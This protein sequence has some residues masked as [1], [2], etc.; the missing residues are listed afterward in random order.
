MK[1]WACDH[2]LINPS[3]KY[4]KFGLGIIC[5]KKIVEDEWFEVC[6]KKLC[7][8][9]RVDK[10]ESVE[11]P[12]KSSLIKQNSD[13]GE[14]LLIL[15]SVVKKFTNPKSGKGKK[16]D[17]CLKCNNERTQSSDTAFDEFYSEIIDAQVNVSEQNQEPLD[18]Y[19]KQAIEESKKE[20]S[21]KFDGKGT[22]TEDEQTI[23]NSTFI[24]KVFLLSSKNWYTLNHLSKDKI[25][26]IKSFGAKSIAC[27]LNRNNQPVP[28][29]LSHLALNQGSFNKLKVRFS[30]TC[31]KEF[32]NQAMGIG[33][34]KSGYKANGDC[35]IIMHFNDLILEF[36]YSKD[37]TFQSVPEIQGYY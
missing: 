23:F 26:R 11:H 24:N 27:S 6:N 14:Q 25:K 37:G 5:G 3:N 19:W 22:L 9:C 30:K 21:S 36:Y 15:G 7:I 20:L 32:Q 28:K 31:I 13:G 12:I 2:E 17:L 10:A 33:N 34:L 16:K 1:C 8:L 18:K 35:F 4:F 29:E